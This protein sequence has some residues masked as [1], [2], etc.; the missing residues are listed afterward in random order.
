MYFGELKH[1]Y[2]KPKVFSICQQISITISLIFFNLCFSPIPIK[3][4]II[5]CIFRV[6]GIDLLSYCSHSLICKKI[7]LLP[8]WTWVHSPAVLQ[9]QSTDTWLWWRKVQCLLQGT[10]QGEWAA[11]AQGTSTLM[12]FREGIL[13][14]TFG[15]RVVACGLSSGQ[16]V[17]RWHSDV[18]GILL[19][20]LLVPTSLESVCL[21]SVCSHQASPGWGRGLR[22]YR[23]TQRFVS[24]C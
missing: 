19:I 13:K 20:S 7:T 8:K 17:V 12:G 23:T 21:W 11:H 14:E 16:L 24:D 10:K 3:I 15:V 9:S 6:L 1:W 18:S 22:F 5:F 4:N 2:L